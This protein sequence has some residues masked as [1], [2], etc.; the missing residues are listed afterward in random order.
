MLIVIWLMLILIWIMLIF[1]T[2]EGLWWKSA[3]AKFFWIF[4]KLRTSENRTTENRISQGPAVCTKITVASYAHVFC[5]SESDTSSVSWL[6]FERIWQTRLHHHVLKTNF[7]F[8]SQIKVS[9]NEW[10]HHSLFPSQGPAS[11]TH[12][13]QSSRS[14]QS[15]CVKVLCDHDSGLLRQRFENTNDS[16]FSWWGLVWKAS[17]G[18]FVIK[19]RT[20]LCTQKVFFILQSLVCIIKKGFSF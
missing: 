3:Y 15:S 11:K 6:S 9:C 1:R 14:H 19:S 12:P 17:N 13:L 4:F 10:L 16:I 2:S 5:H 18:K 8:P 20:C 7:N